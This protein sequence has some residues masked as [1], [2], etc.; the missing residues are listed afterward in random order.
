MKKVLGVIAV[1]LLLLAL[2]GCTM[3]QKGSSAPK[4]TTTTQ[5]NLVQRVSTLEAE[6]ATLK[7]QEAQE[8][9]SVAALSAEVAALQSQAR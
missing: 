4:T 7:T 5:P 1:M 6:V 8:S 3:L 2:T 9:I